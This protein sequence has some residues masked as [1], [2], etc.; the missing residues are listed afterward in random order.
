MQIEALEVSFVL[1]YSLANGFWDGDLQAGNVL[2]SDLGISTYL[3]V[4]EV[5]TGKGRS[6]TLLKTQKR[7]QL[8]HVELCYW[9]GLSSL[10][11]SKMDL[12]TCPQEGAWPWMRAFFG[13]GLFPESDST[14]S[15]WLLHPQKLGKWVPQC[16]QSVAE[17]G[18]KP[19]QTYHPWKPA[20][21]LG[22]PGWKSTLWIFE[23]SIPPP[24][25]GL[26]PL[27]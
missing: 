10:E 13:W 19:E 18:C 20:A 17:Q 8:T 21:C 24:F 14:E 3:R 15:H 6:W 22:S 1:D 12:Y 25:L 4:K 27:F 5:E 7:P 16:P 26:D 11:I 9:N 2:E 23:I